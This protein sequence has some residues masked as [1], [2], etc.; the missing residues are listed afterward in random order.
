MDS[1]SV[2]LVAAAI[3]FS[4][5]L[6]CA[7]FSRRTIVSER[8]AAADEVAV[9]FREPL[10]QAAFNL[11]SRV[12]NIVRQGFLTRFLAEARPTEDREYA[13]ENTL[14]L[15]GQYFCWVEIL[16]RESQYLDPRNQA[17]NRVVT[18]HLETVRD[19]FASS[20]ISEPVFRIFRGEQRAIGE[21]MLTPTDAPHGPR[22]ECRGYAAFVRQRGD[23]EDD[24]WF[25]RTR[26]DLVVLL[27]E[28]G[29]HQERLILVQH[30]LL[31]LVDVLDPRGERVPIGMR[32]R[33]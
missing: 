4:S 7:W 15:L 30:A 6:T 32:E 12:Y 18:E 2:A 28:P 13:A 25:S 9:R 33:L 1:S 20:E 22:W 8:L 21:V 11:Q 10:L 14:Y 27:K 5:A 29:R 19:V 26:K 24:R 23:A 16:L 17:R 31:N 3:S